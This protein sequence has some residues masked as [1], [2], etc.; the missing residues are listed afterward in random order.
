MHGFFS[1]H[2]LEGGHVAEVVGAAAVDPVV[3]QKAD[4]GKN[5]VFL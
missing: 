2:V 1:D 4:H 5:L 3:L